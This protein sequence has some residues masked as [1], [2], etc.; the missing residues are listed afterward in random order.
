MAELENFRREWKAEIEDQKVGKNF[1]ISAIDF[2]KKGSQFESD[3]NLSE[4]GCDR[5]F[6]IVF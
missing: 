3:G 2:W 6:K 5:V 4:V 1:E